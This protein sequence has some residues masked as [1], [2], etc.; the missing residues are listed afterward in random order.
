[1]QQQLVVL[2]L[3]PN[4]TTISI[5]FFYI[6]YYQNEMQHPTNVFLGFNML[7]FNEE[8]SE[9]K[10]RNPKPIAGDH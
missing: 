10:L 8:I 3:R 2:S 7:A 4:A 1:M 6:A 5:L 9:Y